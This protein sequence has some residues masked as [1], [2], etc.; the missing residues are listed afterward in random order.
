[1]EKSASIADGGPALGISPATAGD[2]ERLYKEAIE[3]FGAALVRLVRGYEPVS[4]DDRMVFVADQMKPRLAVID[5]GTNSVTTWV[6]LP[7][8]GYGTA[9]T[10]DGRWLLVAL[11][12]PSEVAVVDLKTLQ[13]VRTIAVPQRPIAIVVATD[14]AAAYVSCGHS[15][16]IAVIKLSDWTVPRVIDAGKH[17]DGLALAASR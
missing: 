3:E 12:Q 15:G 7:G 8:T 2:Q 5:T 10:H 4:A 1:M 13:V 14:D 17:V 6:P 11:L 9:A 16:K